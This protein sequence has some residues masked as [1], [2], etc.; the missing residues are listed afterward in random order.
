[1]T[2]KP[3]RADAQRNRAAIVAAARE[4]FASGRDD[5]R[6]DDFAGLA[7]VGTG[8]LYRHFPTREA[9]AAAVFRD[10]A[11]ALCA[12][13]ATLG[14][15]LP[16]AEALRSFLQEFVAYLDD[17]AGLARALSR[18]SSSAVIDD[19]GLALEAAI[20][21]LVARAVSAGAVRDDIDPGSLLM[22]LHGIASA[23]TRPNWRREADDVIVLIVAGLLVPEGR[24]SRH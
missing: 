21:D 16:P 14:E 10:E 20:R 3:L 18:A 2:A 22:A 19:G 7:G 13:A 12:R 24:Q 1:V 8:T 15:S 11:A 17:H 5:I 4:A 6:F 9:L 23:Q